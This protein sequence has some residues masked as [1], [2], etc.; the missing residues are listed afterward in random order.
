MEFINIWV[1]YNKEEDFRIC[2]CAFDK[3]DA[4]IAAN[5]YC[6][7]AGLSGKFEVSEPDAN[8]SD[9]HFDCDYIITKEK[10]DKE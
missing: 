10:N 2:I 7:D 6:R 3:E 1:G 5:G 8:I 4:Q 9:I